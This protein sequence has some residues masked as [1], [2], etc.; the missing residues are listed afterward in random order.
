MSENIFDLYLKI[1]KYKWV[2][3]NNTLSMLNNRYNIC[4]RKTHIVSGQKVTDYRYWVLEPFE[5]D[6][7]GSREL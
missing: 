1:I 3:N 4:G 7:G 2:I 5:N 6:T